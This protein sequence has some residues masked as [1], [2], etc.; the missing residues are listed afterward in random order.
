M[1]PE[2]TGAVIRIRCSTI[3]QDLPVSGTARLSGSSC[4]EPRPYRCAG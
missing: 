4:E 2:V 1:A 3:W